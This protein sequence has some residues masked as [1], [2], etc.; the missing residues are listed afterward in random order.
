MAQGDPAQAR[1][2]ISQDLVSFGGE[3]HGG[4]YVGGSWCRV[5][6]R[7]LE[8]N[9]RSLELCIKWDAL[10]RRDFD[11]QLPYHLLVHTCSWA[12]SKVKILCDIAS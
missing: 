5:T 2:G 8:M 3:C 1:G 4:L 9:P 11:W 7:W 6:G 12:F 10:W